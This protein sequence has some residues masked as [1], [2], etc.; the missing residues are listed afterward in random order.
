M[1]RQ[2]KSAATFLS[3][4][5]LYKFFNPFQRVLAFSPRFI[6]GL[7]RRALS[8]GFIAGLDCRALDFRQLVLS[9]DPLGEFGDMS[10]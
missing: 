3:F 9:N 1:C 4:I 8:Q 2:A 5:I 7:Y 6:A 10:L